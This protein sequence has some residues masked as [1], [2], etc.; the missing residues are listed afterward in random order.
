MRRHREHP[1]WTISIRQVLRRGMLLTLILLLLPAMVGAEP[2]SDPPAE[3]STVG[4]PPAVDLNSGAENAAAVNDEALPALT[5]FPYA[6]HRDAETTAAIDAAIDAVTH[7]DAVSELDPAITAK[8][9]GGRPVTDPNRW[10]SVVSLQFLQQGLAGDVYDPYAGHICGG[11]VLTSRWVLTAAHC[12]WDARRGPNGFIPPWDGALFVLEGRL[13]LRGSGGAG[14]L[15]SSVLYPA[16]LEEP[17]RWRSADPFSGVDFALLEL[18]TSAAAARVA[19]PKPELPTYGFAYPPPSGIA[20]RDGSLW[21]A[22]WGTT[23]VGGALSNQ[24]MEVDVAFW[25]DDACGR[26]YADFAGCSPELRSEICAGEAGRDACQGD[27]GGPLF[28][29]IG[30]QKWQIGVVSRGDGCGYAER[31]SIYT[32]TPSWYDLIV[33]E[34]GYQPPYG[35]PRGDDPPTAMACPPGQV[36]ATGFVDVPHGGTHA[37]AIDC[38][39]WYGIAR[40][41][42]ATQYAP[43]MEV[44]RAQMASF[45]ARLIEAGG[46]SLPPPSSQGFTDLDRAGVHAERINQL[47]AAGIVRG[48]S[49]TTYDPTASVTRAQM[50][51]FLVNAYEYVAET[52]LPASPSRFTDIAGN[53]HQTNIDKAAAAGFALGTTQTTYTPHRPVRRDQMASFLSRVLERFARDGNTLHHL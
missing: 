28:R 42:T 23:S 35:P 13:S 15:I 30:G 21:A 16:V 45:I 22:G 29:I 33:H 51:T 24:L 36:P 49:S 8:I 6:A 32:W 17:S 20:P 38:V 2:A 48:R 47:A 1:L 25:S 4:Q 37:A 27:S 52:T 12:L 34:T 3:P 53:T 10:P 11:T 31:T 9:V 7:G 18:E 43:R 26:S 50:A 5:S 40:G 41:R 46:G 14:H 19:I 39:A 44:T